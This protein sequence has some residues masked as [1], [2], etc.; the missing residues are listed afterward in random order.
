MNISPNFHSL[1]R[2]DA[3]EFLNRVEDSMSSPVSP[4]TTISSALDVRSGR[5]KSEG[6]IWSTSVIGY[7]QSGV[8]K[9]GVMYQKIPGLLPFR[10]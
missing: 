3:A 5:C 6:W 10:H 8:K 1:P 2:P 9:K 7:Q 4:S